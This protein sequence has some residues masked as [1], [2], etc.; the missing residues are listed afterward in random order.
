MLAW[1]RPMA[2]KIAKSGA[3]P[4]PACPSVNRGLRQ[5]K[6]PPTPSI[7]SSS[8]PGVSGVGTMALVMEVFY[9]EFP[10]SPRVR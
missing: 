4:V 3:A 8:L 1:W 7:H 10:I 5:I 6:N 2:A 9:R